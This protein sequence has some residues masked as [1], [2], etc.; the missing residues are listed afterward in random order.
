MKQILAF[1]ILTMLSA[2]VFSGMAD[3]SER[4]HKSPEQRIENLAKKLD[5]NEEQKYKAIIIFKD[6]HEQRMNIKKGERAKHDPLR[7]ETHQ[8]LS[9]ILTGEQMDTLE[10]LHKKRME[11][12]TKKNQQHNE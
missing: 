3:D 10:K 7:E 11:K 12:R 8:N 4:K 2:P 1:Y 6:S 5:L 9:K